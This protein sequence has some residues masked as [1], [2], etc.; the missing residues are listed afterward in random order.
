MQRQQDQLCQQWQLKLNGAHYTA[1]LAQRRYEQVDPDNRLVARNLERQWEDALLDIERIETQF[2]QHQ[3]NLPILDAAQCRQLTTLAQDLPKV[4]HAQSTSWTQ[5]K[6][7]LQ[8]L[9]ADVTLTRQE[10]DILVQIRWHTNQLDT[11]TVSLPKQGAPPVSEAI[12]ERI[13]ILSQTHTDHRIADE[14]NQ[15]DRQ[16]S[17]GKPFTAQRVQGIR[18]RYSISKQSSNSNQL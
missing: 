2:T 1:R 17:Q 16:I 3:T 9:I 7:L 13:R 15:D 11:F 18:R 8:L 5:R 6:D 10:T 14:L 12:V 4:W